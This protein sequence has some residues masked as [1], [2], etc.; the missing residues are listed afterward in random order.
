[1]RKWPKLSPWVLAIYEEVVVNRDG[2]FFRL[3]WNVSTHRGIATSYSLRNAQ[4][5]IRRVA[6]SSGRHD[7]KCEERRHSSAVGRPV[8]APTWPKS[9]SFFDRSRLLLSQFSY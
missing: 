3:S 5:S 1:M 9:G 2:V 7:A 4:P 8:S 6:A